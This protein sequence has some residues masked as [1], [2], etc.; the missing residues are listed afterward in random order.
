MDEKEFLTRAL[1]IFPDLR[2]EFQELDELFHLQMS[3]FSYR[4]EEEIK[5]RNEET[6]RKSYLLAEKCYLEGNDKMKD[7]VDTC[8]A[9]SVVSSFSGEAIIWAWARFPETLRAL[10]VAMWGKAPI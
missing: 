8:Y 5:S 6:V 4:T 9:E 3:R 2:E 10:Y 1:E 7:A